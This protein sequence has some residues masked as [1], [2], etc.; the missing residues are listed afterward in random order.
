MRSLVRMPPCLAFRKPNTGSAARSNT[1]H[2]ALPC[3]DK[4]TEPTVIHKQQPGWCKAWKCKLSQSS[5]TTCCHNSQGPP[6]T[7]ARSTRK[8]LHQ[9]TFACNRQCTKVVWLTIG[10]IDIHLCHDGKFG[11]PG[12]RKFLHF[13]VAARL[14][15]PELQAAETPSHNFLLLCIIFA[16]L[17]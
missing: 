14:L 10:A 17:Q 8:T 11:A 13:C 16:I 12:L 6:Q 1:C 15:A 5:Y 2:E 9:L 3:G 4:C 7:A